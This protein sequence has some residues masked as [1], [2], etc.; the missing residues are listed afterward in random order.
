MRT[1]ADEMFEDSQITPRI[2]LET[3]NIETVLSLSCTG[4][5]LTFYPKMF[6]ANDPFSRSGLPPCP[7]GLS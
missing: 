3:E 2:V 5:G 7:S 6:I 4:M 1:I